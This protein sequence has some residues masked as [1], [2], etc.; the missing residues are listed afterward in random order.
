ML[1]VLVRN[2]TN[3]KA[4]DVRVNKHDKINKMSFDDWH[5]HWAV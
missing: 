1:T 4:V 3:Y 5:W 2:E